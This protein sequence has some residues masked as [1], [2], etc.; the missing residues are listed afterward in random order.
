[1]KIFIC[2]SKIILTKIELP[3]VKFI[4][5]R[6]MCLNNN[7]TTIKLPDV[8]NIGDDIQSYAAIRFLPKI[9]YYIEREKLDLFLPS[10]KEQVIT[11]GIDKY[12]NIFLYKSKLDF[13][14]IR[15]QKSP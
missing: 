11:K 2:K 10:K 14:S 6:F 15:I 5:D 3:K 7:L 1:M 9:D 8:E 4:G 13:L 12:S